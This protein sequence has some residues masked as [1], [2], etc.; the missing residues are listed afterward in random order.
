MTEKIIKKKE[1]RRSSLSKQPPRSQERKKPALHFPSSKHDDHFDSPQM[2]HAAAS[3]VMTPSQPVA[4]SQGN[5]FLQ[6]FG[7]LRLTTLP[8]LGAEVTKLLQ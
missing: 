8:L 3:Q 4:E 5:A 7:L 1:N 2:I 6:G